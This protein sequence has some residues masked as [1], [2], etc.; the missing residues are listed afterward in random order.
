MADAAQC[1]SLRQALLISRQGKESLDEIGLLVY[2]A[3]V[4]YE[5]IA[6]SLFPSQ[7]GLFV[8]S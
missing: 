6:V 3:M 8:G 4:I 1:F 2:H 7:G 5:I